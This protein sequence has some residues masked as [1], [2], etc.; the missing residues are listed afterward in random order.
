[1][2]AGALWRVA[3]FLARLDIAAS[4]AVTIALLVTLAGR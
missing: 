3:T 1:M 4:L 2:T